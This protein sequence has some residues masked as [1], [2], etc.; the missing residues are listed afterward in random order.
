MVAKKS[1]AVIDEVIKGVMN[2]RTIKKV[3]ADLKDPIS[4]Q[5]WSN[6]LAK[7]QALLNRYHQAKI[8][9]LDFQLAEVKDELDKCVK[10]SIDPKAVSMSRVNLLKIKSANIQWELSKLMPKNYG[11]SQQIQVST[12]KDEAFTIRWKE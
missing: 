8:S 7:D 4:F 6:W 9:A 1:K 2:G 5:A 10:D 3:L 11:T 12:P